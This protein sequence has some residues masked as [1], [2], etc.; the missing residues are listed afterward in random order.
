M[1]ARRPAE[2]IAMWEAMLPAARKAFG[3]AHSK[4]LITTSLLCGAYESLGRWAQ[5]EIRRRELIALRRKTAPRESSTLAGDLA[6]LGL[7]LLK[8]QKWAQA[9]TALRECLKLRETD[10]HAGWA[11]F[12]TRSLLGDSLLAQQKYAEAEPLI[13]GGYEGMRAREAKIPAQDRARL[14]EAV[15]R[16]VKLYEAWAKPNQA[17]EWRKKLGIVPELPDD[18]F[19]RLP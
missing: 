11:T 2:A 16:A 4:T 9:E 5:A 19:A 12:N 14:T 13:I 7:I 1:A 3:P 18:P 8:Q 10:Q 17:A 15:Q 6:G